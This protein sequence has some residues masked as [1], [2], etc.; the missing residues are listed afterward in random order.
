MDTERDVVL[1]SILRELPACDEE[2]LRGAAD[3]LGLKGV[4][5]I[6]KRKLLTL[7]IRHIC[8]DDFDPEEEGG[9]PLLTQLKDLI[10]VEA[11]PVTVSMSG[12]APPQ[13]SPS[14]SLSEIQ[15]QK[16]REFKINGT[17]GEVCQKETL[18]YTSLSFQLKQGKESGYST[19]EIIS[20]VIRAIKPGTPLRTY[21]ET[22]IDLDEASLLKILRSH[23]KERDSTAVFNEMVNSVQGGQE[24]ELNF[25]LRMMALRE[26][27][28]SLSAEENSSCQF[29]RELVSNRFFHT[30]A[31]GFKKPQI[32]LDLKEILKVGTSDEALLHEISVA[33][34]K[35]NEYLSKVKCHKIDVGEVFLGSEPTTL[36][37][38]LDEINS[39]M[40]EM[41]SELSN[42]KA[43]QGP[44]H[45]PP[46]TPRKNPNRFRCQ[47]CAARNVF[48]THCLLCGM[49]GHKKQQCPKNGQ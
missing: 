4:E 13:F 18:S 38:Q 43:A 20:G 5:E 7:V 29:D 23:F 30:L 32:R 24:T 19:K 42:L 49:G 26:K 2:R 36:A 8:A 41:K 12:S 14:E 33:V 11:K 45:G 22:R 1:N 37:K 39:Q 9:L 46:P 44:P 28:I 35:D 27:I 6:G 31:T 16:L 21:L 48:C 40:R 15:V 34:S 17:I 3:I 10:S 25:C 47:S